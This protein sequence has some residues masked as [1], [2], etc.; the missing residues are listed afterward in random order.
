MYGCQDWKMGYHRVMRIL[1]ALVLLGSSA[2]ASDSPKVSADLGNCNADFHVVGA[3]GKPIY[4]ARV[5]TLIKYGAFSLRKT[6][7]EVRTDSNG[8]AGVINLPNYSK[9]PIS[10][11]VSNGSFSSTVQFTPDKTC[12]AKYE[13]TLK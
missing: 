11:E 8:Q 2:I 1:L 5:H 7:L 13:I 4:N 12:Q 10:F 9:K 3:D 6:D